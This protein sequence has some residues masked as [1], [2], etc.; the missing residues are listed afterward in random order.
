MVSWF[1][2]IGIALGVATLI[3]VMSVMNGFRTELMSKILG[4]NGHINITAGKSG[5]RDFE[6]LS[7]DLKSISGAEIATPV[8]TGQIMATFEGAAA[9][10]QVIGIKQ[11]DL[12]SKRIVSENITDGSAEN[13]DSA[14][15]VLVGARL[16]QTL[17]L[18]VGSEVSLIS[19][20]GISSVMGMV[21]RVK[22]YPVVGIFEVGMFD[23][24][25]ATILMPLEAAQTYFQYYNAVSQIELRLKDPAEA[26]AITR[27]LV[28]NLSSEYTIYDWQ[29]ANAHF[30]GA[31]K[32]ERNVMFLILT[33]IILV[34]AFNIISSMIMLVK[35]KGKNIAILR[36]MGV[37]RASVMRIFLLTGSSIG[38]IGTMAGG[39][40]GLAFA[41]NIE[42][43]RRFLEKMLNVELFSAEIYYL[44]QLPVQVKS[45]EAVTVIIMALT[46]SILA[47]IYP[48]WK[49]ARI[50]PAE[51]L[52][53][54]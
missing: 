6:K 3:V 22:S 7:A 13:F 36:A 46:L 27:K 11:I 38:I 42:S 47:T 45:E 49:A 40:L 29:R 20:R 30:V 54:G 33:M 37:P 12:E 9:G 34:A 2:L 10:A 35:D 21:P 51:A 48:A 44:T 32:T 8:V 31:L 17:G 25:S 52:R 41:L 28:S 15:G 19:P 39:G 16:A 43:I 26:T 53:Y 5:I 24:D 18:Q 50:D 23:Y 14:G 1:S 4:V